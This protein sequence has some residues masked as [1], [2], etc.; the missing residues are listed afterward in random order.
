[1]HVEVGE[2]IALLEGHGKAKVDGLDARVL[3]LTLQHKVTW[4][5]VTVQDVVRVALRDRLE[6]RP[7]VRSDLQR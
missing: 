3:V 2:V 6:R 5:D 1:M 4:L 7:H